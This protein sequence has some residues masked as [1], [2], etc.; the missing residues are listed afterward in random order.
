MK[1]FKSV[2]LLFAAA[3]LPALSAQVTNSI[4][5]AGIKV[6]VQFPNM[7]LENSRKEF[8]LQDAARYFSQ[9][10]RLDYPEEAGTTLVASRSGSMVARNKTFEA[11]FRFTADAGITNLVVSETLASLYGNLSDWVLRTNLLAK[12]DEFLSCLDA[13]PSSFSS[14]VRRSRF[15]HFENGSFRQPSVDEASDEDV[16]QSLLEIQERFSFTGA[17]ILDLDY[18]EE[19]DCWTLPLRFLFQSGTNEFEKAVLSTPAVFVD[20]AWRLLY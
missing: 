7:N 12:A 18:S 17:C 19:F 8:I 2:S 20:G 10:I 13:N 1:P 15:R 6:Q 11:G 4:S 16:V 5:V 14:G 9:V 3:L